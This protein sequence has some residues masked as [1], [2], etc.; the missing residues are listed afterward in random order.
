MPTINATRM[1]VGDSVAVAAYYRGAN[2]AP[3]LLPNRVRAIL[4]KFNTTMLLPGVDGALR[5][6]YQPG[7]YRE[8][9]GQT[10]A[11]ADQQVGLVVDAARSRGAELLPAWSSGFSSLTNIGIGA[12]AGTVNLVGSEVVMVSGD[13]GADRAE[14]TIGGLV[15]NRLYEARIVARRGTQGS[16][17][18]FSSWTVGTIN[19]VSIDSTANKEYVINFVA[20]G[21]GGLIRA[22]AA[23]TA[24]G[25]I[26][27]GVI[28][29]SISVREL[30]GIHASQ[31]TS[32]FQPVLRNTGGIQS[33]QFDGTDDR[34]ALSAV[35]FQMS[36]DFAIVAGTF[37]DPVSSVK[38]NTL[39]GASSTTTSSRIQLAIRPDTGG[40]VFFS[41]DDLGTTSLLYS[42]SENYLR[43]NVVV[44]AVKA[45]NARSIRVDGVT[46][47]SATLQLYTATLAGAD[48]GRLFDASDFNRGHI[49]AIICIKGNP[50]DSE[51][52]ILE[53][54]IA[55]LQGRTL[56]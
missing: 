32:G 54:F 42:P 21:T 4:N 39:F 26:G 9:T 19:R 45:G 5:F 43:K 34:L 53:K 24:G 55:S 46:R 18:N 44:S 3:L 17:Q 41:R 38:W 23:D 7:N 1:F 37:C 2:V 40:A 48:I 13:G 49:H 10:L 56:P 25:A 6:G 50:T 16:S 35:P 33:W 36:D 31:S 30:P 20:S 14:F 8:S 12:S 52:L 22:Y 28:V 29:S 47:V 27:D 51:L 15:S 11:A